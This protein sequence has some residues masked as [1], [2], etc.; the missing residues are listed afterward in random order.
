MATIEK[1]TFDRIYAF[2]IANTVIKE[3]SFVR[4]AKRLDTTP[5]NITKEVQKLE[6]HL[7]VTLFN[8]TTRSLSLT[9]E[10]SIAI[11]K[12]QS[13]LDAVGQLEEDL[14]GSKGT[15]KGPLTI[16]APKALG[17]TLI[18]SLIA[19]FQLE[20]PYIEI[21]LIFSDRVLDPVQNRVDLS[22]RTA[23]ELED[24]SLYVKKLGKL[25]RVICASPEYLEMFKRPRN[26]KD[27]QNHNCLVYMRGASPLH[28][29]MEKNKVRESIKIKGSY[30]SNNLYSLIEACKMG[31]GLLNIPK[32]LV[33]NSIDNGELVPL[34]KSWELPAHSMFLLSSNKPSS[35]RK[36][37]A[38]I[39]FL[40]KNLA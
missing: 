7:G 8:R 39:E 4:A 29:T 23:F 15:I 22:I 24:S 18:S 37:S 21:D 11:A 5:S 9:E 14:Q 40:Q 35:S 36:L 30:R 34:F 10:G 27:L 19:Q 2:N 3:G 17:Q 28:W 1:T 12:F 20:N 6:N 38:I 26:T 16:T 13:I 33:K 31:I 32:Y 25:E